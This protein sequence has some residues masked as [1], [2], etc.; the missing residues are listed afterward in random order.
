VSDFV[1][2]VDFGTS[3]SLVAEG[4]T[5]RDPRTVP[6]GETTSWMPSVAAHVDDR[7]VAGEE[8]ERRAPQN[9]IRS[10]K[11]AI[12]ENRD[13]SDYGLDAEG[14]DRVITAVLTELRNRAV[15]LGLELQDGAVRLGCPAMWT[16]AQ[17]SRLIRLAKQ[18]G[19]AVQTGTL[20]DEPIAAGVA[21]VMRRTRNL[22]AHTDGKVLVYDMGGGTLDVAV[23]HVVGGPGEN[24][25]INVLA[26]HGTAEAGDSVDE[27]VVGHYLA[28]NGIDADSLDSPHVA[29]AYIRRAAREAKLD[30]TTSLRASVPVQST[31]TPLPDL[32]LDR[33]E[34]EEIIAPQLHRS[35]QTIDETIRASL[36]TETLDASHRQYTPMELRRMGDDEL[37]DK[38]SYVLLAGGMSRT[39]AVEQ[40]LRSVF[41]DAEIHT[42]AD[43]P[44][45]EAIAVGL[46]ETDTYE[47]LSLHRPGFDFVL[48]WKGRGGERRE[49]VLYEAYS[50]FYSMQQAFNTDNLKHSF[51]DSGRI[52]PT[53]NDGRLFVRSLEGER[54]KFTLPNGAELDD[55][56]INFGPN[57]GFVISQNGQIIINDRSTR[58]LKLD[59]WPVLKGSAYGDSLRVT[60]QKGQFARSSRR[61]WRPY[62]DGQ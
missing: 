22:R 16:G 41:P 8:A 19:I 60:K 26:A 34:F 25:E 58:Q 20:I 10:I 40:H 51:H 37:H 33:T 15:D 6:V 23:L 30:L 61:T 43:V 56:A 47:R 59:C 3:T 27:S 35:T 14:I 21:W 62:E 17:R 5:S 48:E 32:E 46:A 38:I 52:L 11:R 39:P 42:I 57:F 13:F 50:P 9:L 54:V 12:T 7:V 4:R 2:G 28:V 18:S 45:D 1:I 55:I 29:M 44:P 31:G 49:H 36:L 24:P 53:M